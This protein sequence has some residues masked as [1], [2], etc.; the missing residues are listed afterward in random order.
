[1]GLVEE[2]WIPDG[3]VS[4]LAPDPEFGGLA[5]RFHVEMFSEE[6]WKGIVEVAQERFEHARA[7]LRKDQ[8]LAAG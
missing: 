3:E 4:D 6:Q 1:M 8:R 5:G 7:A 2:R